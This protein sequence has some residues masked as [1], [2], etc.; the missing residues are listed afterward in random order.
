MKLIDKIE[1][2]FFSIR[3]KLIAAFMITIIPMIL[4]GIASYNKSAE[5]VKNLATQSTIQTMEQTNKYLDLLLW[6]TN[7]VSIQV[8]E[9]KDIQD[10]LTGDFQDGSAGEPALK[11]AY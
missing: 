6:N 1:K 10:Y 5:S 3:F 2:I 4:L 7:A 9:N 11:K 8:S